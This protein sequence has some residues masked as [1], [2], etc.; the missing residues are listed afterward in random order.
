MKFS[1]LR[2]ALLCLLLSAVPA[3][4]QQPRGMTPADT[5]RVAGVG[6]AQIAP[7]GSAVCY[8]VS[9][10]KGNASRTA[11]WCAQLGVE[12]AAPQQVLGGDWNVS[13][14]RWS[15]DSRRLAFLASRGEQ[16]GLWTVAPRSGQ[17]RF[18]APVRSTNFFITYAGESFAWSPDS[19]RIAYV[20]ASDESNDATTATAAV[21]AANER[22]QKRDD[23]RIVDRI[24][25]KSRTAFSDTL[26]T[27][28]WLTDVDEPQPRQLTSGQYYDHALT[29]NPRGDEIAFLSNHETDPDAV[30]NS[31]IFAVTTDG[32]V[33]QIT[34]TRGCEY[35]PAWSPDGKWIAYAATTREVTTIDSVAEDAHVW[36]VEAA[37]GRGRELA[38]AQD[39]RARS[40]RWSP[41]GANVLYL[42]GDRGRTSIYQVSTDGKTWNELPNLASYQNDHCR[43]APPTAAT[44]PFQV[45]NFSQTASGRPVSTIAM[46]VGD[47]LHPAEVWLFSPT[48]CEAARRVSSHNEGLLRSWSLASPEEIS[49][50]SFDGTRVQGWLLKPIG[51]RE[52]ERYPLVLSIHGG[53]HGMFGHSFNA[54]F[55]TYA[56]RGYAVLYINP[57]GSSGYGQKFSDGTLREWGGGDYRDLMAGVDEA[58]RRYTWIDRTRMG[59]TGGSYGGFMTNW[60]ITQTPRFRAAVASASVSNL[61]SFYSTSLYQDLIHAEFGGF[62]WDDYDLLW[63][64]SPL[65]YVRAVETPTLFIHGEQDNDVHITQA[66]EMYMALRRRGVE[67]VL[68]RYP[69]EGHGL[70]EPRHRQDALERT[71]DWFDKYLK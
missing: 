70:R 15:P 34:T 33:R 11:L 17:P 57:R 50:R 68:A 59:V 8:T 7:D 48:A 18:V 4:A 35:D 28:V 20:N 63:R 12:R 42:A 65:R 6:D 54:A 10:V 9:T 24:Q 3:F 53:P 56:A 61:V 1:R 66:E 64:W 51:W 19:R 38:A 32:R 36:I 45:G 40:P 25:Y 13:R 29:W 60:I 69:R 39:R 62:P 55:Q 21:A 2:S 43:N 31:D 26:R 52:T 5:L 37:G 46:T 44:P 41:G 67:S 23:P 14:P 58:L 22:E 16:S 49:F 30:N 47:A 27:H 71:I